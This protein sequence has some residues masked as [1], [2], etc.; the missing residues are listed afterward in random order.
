MH[1]GIWREFDTL[2]FFLLITNK[3][4]PARANHRIWIR[5]CLLRVIVSYHEF[6]NRQLKWSLWPSALGPPGVQRYLNG[7]KTGVGPTTRHPRVMG[8][9]K[10]KIK[11]EEFPTSMPL[12]EDS[13]PKIS[14]PR[15]KFGWSAQEDQL[16]IEL[17][18]SGNTWVQVSKMLGR[19]ESTCR[20]HYHALCKKLVEWD[21][22]MDR[23]L[24]KYYQRRREEMWKGFERE[25]GVPWKAAEDRM[26]D[27]Q[28]TKRNRK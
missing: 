22:E 9:L 16:C 1:G 18:N 13:E 3:T 15:N 27:L 19:P 14:T 28:K 11:N 5:L 10:E 4:W 25:L 26:W 8:K 2:Q 23:K 17:K 21:D 20:A 6:G 7:N 12:T 24:E